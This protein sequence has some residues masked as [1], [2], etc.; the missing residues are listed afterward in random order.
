[1]NSKFNVIHRHFLRAIAKYCHGSLLLNF[2]EDLNLFLEDVY[3][4]ILKQNKF[5]I[6]K[7]KTYF[8]KTENVKYLYKI[9]NDLDFNENQMITVLNS[10]FSSIEKDFYN[11]RKNYNI[12]EF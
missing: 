8:F 4:Y 9:M 2:S 5:D 7:T 6:K 1:M 11:C 3:S 10:F 12:N